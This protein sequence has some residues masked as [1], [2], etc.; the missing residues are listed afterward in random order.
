MSREPAKRT[1]QDVLRERRGARQLVGVVEASRRETLR[2][3]DETRRIAAEAVARW[4]EGRSPDGRS[5]LSVEVYR[6]V[7][8]LSS[9]AYY[10]S[11]H[12]ARRTRAQLARAP[13]CEVV[14]CGS[15]VDVAVHHLTHDALGEEQ[16]SRHLVTLC[17]GCYKRVRKLGRS[18]ARVPAREEVVALDPAAPIYDSSTIAALKAKYGR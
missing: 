4:R 13:A 7:F 8:A 3:H 10:A 15:T 12:W 18:L 14:A 1:L 2:R 6:E 11:G 16:P 9:E 5:R 17:D